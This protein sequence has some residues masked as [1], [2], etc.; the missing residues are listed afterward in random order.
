MGG[1]GRRVRS[2]LGGAEVRMGR[3]GDV[4][5]LVEV[6]GGGGGGGWSVCKAWW[7]FG[8]SWMWIG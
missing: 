2:T 4:E 6:G 5:E 8:K 3:F 7:C 1:A